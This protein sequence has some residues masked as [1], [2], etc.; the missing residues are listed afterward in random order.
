MNKYWKKR[1]DE[2]KK[3][4]SKNEKSLNKRLSKYYEKE[5]SRLDKEIAAYYT[6]Y[7]KDNVIEYRILLE[8]LPDEDIKLL[9]EKIDDFVYKYPKYA[10]LVPV[11]ESIYKLNRLEG[12]Q[13]SIIMQQHEMAMK[14]QEEVTE[15]LNNLA[16]KSANTSMEAMGFGKNFYSVNDQIVKNFVDTPWSNGESFSTRIW[17][18]TNKLANYLN[19]DIAQGFAR[20][21][22]YAKLT[23]SLRNRFIKVSKNDAYRLIYTEGTYV[24]AEATMQPFIEDFEHYRIS[25]VGDGQVCPVCKEMSSKV[26]NI[27][28]RQ[29]GVNFPPLHPWCRCTFEIVVDDWDKWMDDYVARHGQSDQERSNSIIENFSMK[30]PLDLQMFSK[31]P[32]DY[33]TI[34]LSKKEYAHVMSELNTNL[35]KEQLK[36]KIV[37]KPIGDYIYT[38]EVIEFGNYRIIGK[39]L[40]DETVG[41]KL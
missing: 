18:N 23:S 37:S 6:K 4:A 30:F 20:G 14:D 29:A 12:L 3:W 26:F 36:H 7:G 32:K 22:S 5:F 34:I 17:N 25:T 39:K 11:R 15:Y 40:I 35:T 21:D 2:L 33:D 13:Y 27:G 8:K 10:H 28:D 1:T 19:T 38:I 9:M 16:A 24:M 41:R 31:R